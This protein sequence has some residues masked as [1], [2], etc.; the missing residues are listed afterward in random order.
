MTACS[1]QRLEGHALG[2]RQV[3]GAFDGGAIGSDAGALLLRGRGAHPDHCATG[4]TAHDGHDARLIEHS[5]REVVG[6]RVLALAHCAGRRSMAPTS[7]V[8]RAAA[9]ALIVASA[10]ASAPIGA[11]AAR[12]SASA[13]A[14]SGS[15][16][17]RPSPGRR[18]SSRPCTIFSVPSR[19]PAHPEWHSP[20]RPFAHLPS[21]H[22]SGGRPRHRA[23][24]ACTA[25]KRPLR[26]LAHHI[27][28]SPVPSVPPIPSIPHPH[29]LF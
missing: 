22:R 27:H 15:P 24:F 14:G 7:R 21:L 23:P 6:Q 28:G 4:A 20:R 26:A 2:R 18:S 9:S 1:A 3:A 19:C 5:V 11:G 29:P 25:R 12:K 16:F 10:A 8:P 17:P 13:Y